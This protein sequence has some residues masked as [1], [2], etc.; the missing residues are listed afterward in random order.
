MAIALQIVQS[1]YLCRTVNVTVRKKNAVVYTFLDIF[2]LLNAFPN[3]IFVSQV[4]FGYECFVQSRA[5]V[6]LEPKRILVMITSVLLTSYKKSALLLTS[7][8]R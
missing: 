8:P 5:E 3:I 1:F 4:G 6:V 2:G 7:L